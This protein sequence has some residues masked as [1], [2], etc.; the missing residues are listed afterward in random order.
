MFST[1]RIL[2]TKETRPTKLYERGNEEISLLDHI[3]YVLILYIQH[4]EYLVWDISKENS[5]VFRFSDAYGLNKKLISL[6][7]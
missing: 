4:F 6:Y 2:L 1:Y 3:V 5:N 7:Y